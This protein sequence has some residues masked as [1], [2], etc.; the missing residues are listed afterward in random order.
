MTRFR[1]ILHPTDFSECSDRAFEQACSLARDYGAKLLL[2]HVTQPPGAV[3]YGAVV[4][5]FE[6]PGE[7]KALHDR[8]DALQSRA[9]DIV[10]EQNLRMGD[11]AAQIIDLATQKKCDLIVMG[12][13][14]RSGLGHL[15]LGSVA[16]QVVRK[17]PCP[18]LTV[19]PP[20]PAPS[21]KSAGATEVDVSHAI[22]S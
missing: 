5:P 9:S 15:I 11:A 16:E 8:L 1:T 4:F 17:A 20:P 6:W 3:K 10:V 12:T 13:H 21:D 2:Q 18:V 14:G 22:L 19:K 7:R